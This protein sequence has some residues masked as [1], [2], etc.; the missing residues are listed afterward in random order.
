VVAVLLKVVFSAPQQ[1]VDLTFFAVAF[2]CAF[3]MI[4]FW[5]KF[6]KALGF[7]DLLGEA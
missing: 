3:T 1:L 6:A 7:G 4:W 5:R 2:L